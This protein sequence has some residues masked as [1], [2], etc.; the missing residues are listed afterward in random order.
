MLAARY[1]HQTIATTI[2]KAPTGK[3][4]YETHANSFKAASKLNQWAVIKVMFEAMRESGCYLGS[5]RTIVWALD[6]NLKLS[7]YAK[8]F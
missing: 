3:Q 5:I 8:V 4:A 2:I 7:R 6:N 1:G